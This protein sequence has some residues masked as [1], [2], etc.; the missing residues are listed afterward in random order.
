M[1]KIIQMTTRE[2][3]L[4]AGF[5]EI[6]S[7]AHAYQL[8][9]KQLKRMARYQQHNREAKW[10]IP[11]T[12]LA[13]KKGNWYRYLVRERLVYEKDADG[14]MNL[15][16]REKVRHRRQQWISLVVKVVEGELK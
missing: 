8:L 5:R 3:L 10:N 9:R 2:T 16:G 1:E 4:S 12:L 14:R 11:A 13:I 7:D 15:V 6:K